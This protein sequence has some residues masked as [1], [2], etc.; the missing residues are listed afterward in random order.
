MILLSIWVVRDQ[1]AQFPHSTYLMLL[2]YGLFAVG[3]AALTWRDWWL[4]ARLA[5]PAHLIDMGIFTAIAFSIGGSTN[6]FFLFFILPLLSAAIRWSWRETLLTATVLILIHLAAGILLLTN[7]EAFA[8]QRFIIRSGHLLIL[9]AVLIWFGL[10]Q[11]FTRLSFGVD[12]FDR[13]IGR[14]E[15]PLVQAL[16]LLMTAVRARGGALLVGA[17]DTDT[18]KGIAMVGG[19]ATSVA[20]ARPLMTETS[21]VVLFDLG[22]DRSLWRRDHGWYHFPSASKLIDAETLGRLGADEGL[23]AQVRSGTRCGWLLLWG[24]DDLSVDFLD[25]GV[26]LGRTAGGVLDHNALVS[27]IEDGAAARTRLSLARDVHDNVVQFLAAATFRVE[28][29]IRGGRRGEQVEAD[30]KELKHL[31]IEEQ[32][33]I[34]TFVSALRRDRDLKLAEAVTELKTLAR[35]LEQQWSIK[36]RV[37][38]GDDS[39]SIPIELHLDLQQLLREAVANAVRHGHAS[40]VEVAVG[41][42]DEGVLMEVKDNGSGFGPINGSAVEPWSLKER[43]DR[44]RG[45]LSLRSEEGSTNILITLPLA[46]LPA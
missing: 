1:S 6:P 28:A 42:G 29:I 21:P 22:R 36:C 35:R 27:A 2:V 5:A 32:G 25:L 14:G 38:S 16:E 46:G 26:E 30:L 17:T 8:E 12:D 39:V 40:C 44:A 31:L 34:R 15:D 18:F 45:S 41:I 23:V 13:R 3:F 37:E 33:E 20:T 9:S 4:D 7:F 10:H 43:V 11:Q 19:E 24:I